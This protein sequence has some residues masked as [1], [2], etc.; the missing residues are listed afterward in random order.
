MVFST[1]FISVLTSSPCLAAEKVYRMKIQSGYPH[2]DLSIELLKDFASSADKKS[3]G[4]LKISMFT[5]PEIEP[6]DQFIRCHL[7]S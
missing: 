3:G 2:G 7:Y 6:V 4:R 1:L 5:D